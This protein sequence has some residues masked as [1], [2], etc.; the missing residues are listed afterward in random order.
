MKSSLNI[1]N[2]ELELIEQYLEKKLDQNAQ[3]GFEQYA[4]NDPEWNKKVEEVRYL[5]LNI[6]ETD[7]RD[8]LDQFHSDLP[9]LTESK[10][11]SKPVFFMSTKWL[12]AASIV[13]IAGLLFFWLATKQS[14]YEKIYTAYFK[15]DPGLLAVMGNSEAYAF[16]RAMVDYKEGNFEKAIAAWEQLRSGQPNSDTLNYFL[17]VANLALQRNE[18][19][20]S[21]LSP[22][23]ENKNNSFWKE[24]CWYRGLILLKKGLKEEALEFVAK[25]N[26]PKRDDLL[27]EFKQ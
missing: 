14:K 1:S 8:Q 4:K 27:K 10:P 6:Q 13:L 22:I 23:S 16:E 21:F 17:G 11:S 24:A 18:K 3:A 15:P 12:A 25:S 20:L 9:N 26:H 7:L 5:L 2:Q 19:A